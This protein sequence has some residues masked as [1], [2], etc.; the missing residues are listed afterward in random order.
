MRRKKNKLPSPF[1]PIFK[2]M[3]KS[4]AWEKIGCP[5]RVAYIHLKGKC[6]S[7]SVGELTLSFNEMERIMERRTFSNALKELEAN[8]FI[9]R[10]Q[11]GGLHRKRN[12]FKLDEKWKD[13]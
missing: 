5:A 12:Y 9:V 13:L 6:C 2:D 1:V 7:Q 10:T 4:Q 8:G 3:L 11:R